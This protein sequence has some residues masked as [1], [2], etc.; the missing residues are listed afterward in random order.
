MT[1][2]TNN[3]TQPLWIRG[4]GRDGR[5]VFSLEGTQ[6]LLRHADRDLWHMIDCSIDGTYADKIVGRGQTKKEAYDNW[7]EVA[8]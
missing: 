1:K 7:M 3:P 2:Q 6:M 4:R 5:M 8:K